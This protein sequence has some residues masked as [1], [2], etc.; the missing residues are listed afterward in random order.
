M[1]DSH[2]DAIALLKAD[3]RKVERLFEQFEAL[4]GTSS[5]K[6]GNVCREAKFDG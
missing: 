6:R 2:A 1:A 3:H 5:G 4:K